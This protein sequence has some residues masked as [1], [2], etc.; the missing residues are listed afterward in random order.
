MSSLF[1]EVVSQIDRIRFNSFLL[2]EGSSLPR[3]SSVS[4]Y[5]ILPFQTCMRVSDF[6][7]FKLTMSTGIIEPDVL[8]GPFGILY[9][10]DGLPLLL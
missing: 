2:S 9:V 3:I 8:V 7:K 1:E 6:M 10:K 4:L 5:T